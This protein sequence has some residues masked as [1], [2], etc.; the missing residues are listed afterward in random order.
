MS[1]MSKVFRTATGH[2]YV[3]DQ[4]QQ[5]IPELDGYFNLVPLLSIF[6]TKAV[7]KPTLQY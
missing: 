7:F 4:A 3:P 6:R 5:E 2:Q 1:F